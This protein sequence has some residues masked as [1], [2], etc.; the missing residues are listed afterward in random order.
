MNLRQVL[1]DSRGRE[2]GSIE[3]RN[4]DFVLYDNLN[5]YL[6]TFDSSSNQTYDARNQFIGEG[7]LLPM[8]LHQSYNA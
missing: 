4:E 3:R 1:R 2:L 8:L 6:G 7:N 5:N